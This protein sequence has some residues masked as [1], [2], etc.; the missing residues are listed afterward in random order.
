MGHRHLFSTS[1]MFENEH[2][3]NWN[4]MHATEQHFMHLARA[5]TSENGSFFYPVENMSVDGAHYTSHWSPAPRSIGYPS[6][7]HN[8]E[9]PPYQPDPPGP[10]HEPF[11]HLSPAGT[12]S[13]APDTYAQ[14]ASSS[15][16]DRQPFH[17]GEGSFIDLTVGSGRGPH[18]RKSPGNP[19]V[20]ERGSTS[21]YYNAGSSSDLPIS[22]EM[23]LEKPNIDAQH[24]PWDHFNVNPV[25]RGN[26]LSIRVEDSLRNVRSRSALDLESNLART[27]LSSNPPHPSYSASHPIEHSSTVDPLV[28]GSNSMTRDWSHISVSPAPGRVL[29]SDTSSFNH[30]TNQLLI[31]SGASNSSAEIGGYHHDFVASRNPVAPQSFHANSTQSVRGV[32]SSFT[33][34]SGPTFRASS[35]S[36]R[37]GHVAPSDEGLQ[38]VAESHSSRHPRPLSTIGW[39]NGDRNGRSRISTER[40]RSLPDEAGLHDR[41]SSEGFMIVDRSAMYGSRNMFDQHRDMRLDIDNM[42]YEEL[43]ALGERIGNVNTGVSEDLIS[44]CLRET[45]YCSSDQTQEEPTC[46]ICLEEYKDMV[47][48]GTLK[49]CGHDYHVSCIKKWLS[50]KNLCPVCK[51]PALADN[52]KDK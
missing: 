21:R 25:Y 19:S 40:Y 39:R 16:Y 32:R 17:C 12:F 34:R 2:D 7:S 50:M 28:Q 43:L 51:A 52:T 23:R 47:G 48:V 30:E 10:S 31:G 9:V 18:K 6:S 37:L 20:C 27:H 46:V 1:Q 11:A 29:V 3:Q 36:L 44:K 22:S 41:F 14:H 5:G 8:V 38:L 15:N 26:G 49:T 24:L 33:Q 13:T 45:I 35:S 4:H 42:G